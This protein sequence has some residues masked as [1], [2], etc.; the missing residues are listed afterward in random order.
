MSDDAAGSA[1]IPGLDK[2]LRLPTWQALLASA[3]AK[4]ARS[5]NGRVISANRKAFAPRS[6]CCAT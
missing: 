6:A 1:D 2:S 3:Q 5:R 4:R